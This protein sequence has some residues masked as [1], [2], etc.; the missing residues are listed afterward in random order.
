MLFVFLLSA[1]AF[2]LPRPGERVP[3]AVIEGN[4]GGRTDGTAWRSAD[5]LGRVMVV[6]YV[7]P[8]ERELNDPLYEALKREDF[9][10]DKSQ[11]VAIINM[12]ATIMPN[13]LISTM[14]KKKQKQYPRTL[15]VRDRQSVLVKQWGLADNSSCVTVVDAN[16]RLVFSQCGRLSDPE[17]KTCIESIWRAINN[18]ASP[19]SN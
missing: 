14:L 18:G 15:Y 12:A 4:D 5:L 1:A 2:P 17:I 16:G 13:F 8:D 10:L 7:D 11:S 19:P 6:Y 3:I 9:P